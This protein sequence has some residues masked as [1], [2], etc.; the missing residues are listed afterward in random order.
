MW[1]FPVPGWVPAAQLL[2]RPALEGGW[3]QC[4]RL[5]GSSPCSDRPQAE[6]PRGDRPQGG[7]MQRDR[8]QFIWAGPLLPHPTCFPFVGHRKAESL[9][10]WM[11]SSVKC[12]GGRQKEEQ[13]VSW[14]I[15]FPRSSDT[16]CYIPYIILSLTWLFCI[17]A[18]HPVPYEYNVLLLLLQQSG[19]TSPCLLNNYGF[20]FLEKFA[21]FLLN[22]FFK[23]PPALVVTSSFCQ[24]STF[25]PYSQPSVSIFLLS[26]QICI[27]CHSKPP[28]PLAQREMELP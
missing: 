25:C 26:S 24:H 23:Y 1:D 5:Q 9:L 20:P 16:A 22:E 2:D 8:P 13:A 21:E 6:R 27:S 4:C 28:S 19:A 3:L 7:R 15:S 12:D 14:V 18:L 17:S 10:R 11:Q